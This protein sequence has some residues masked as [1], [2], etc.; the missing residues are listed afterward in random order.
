MAVV[1]ILGTALVRILMGNS[2]F[3]NRQDA[4][5]DARMT[6][7]AAMN[8]MAPELRMVSDSGLETATAKSVVVRVPYGFGLTCQTSGGSVIAS[9]IP[10]DS[11]MFA[12]AVP[13][14]M[15]WRDATGAYQFTAGVTVSSS[16]D[17]AA[18]DADSVRVLAGGQRIA[19]ATTDTIPS[20][21]IFYLY[22]R[23]TYQFSASVELA[24]RIGLWRQ[25]GS[26]ANE[27]LAWP[28]DTA[29]GFGFL[30]GTAL[31]ALAAPPADLTTVSGLELKLLGM[32]EL[33]P[34]GDSVPR[35]FDLRTRLTFMNAAR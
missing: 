20:G 4:M 29:A 22:Q 5:M 19:I 3:V 34:Q 8:V 10:T 7:R 1:A 25:R 27:E 24:G 23:V 30:V 17:Q 13:D 32:S 9:L 16:T 12:T 15:A 6:A 28:F 18:C 21:S 26:G 14:G 33:V 11:V 2:R 35:T 31:D